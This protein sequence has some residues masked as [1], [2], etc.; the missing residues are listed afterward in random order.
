M[1]DKIEPALTAEQ[2]SD[3]ARDAL[4]LGDPQDK[5][6]PRIV[7][8]EEGLSVQ[9]DWGEATGA[10]LPAVIAIA[11]AALPDTDPRKITR[12]KVAAMRQAADEF[13]SY[14]GRDYG[15]KDNWGRAPEYFAAFGTET[16]KFA[17]ALASYLPA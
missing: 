11:N 17:D 13:L 4:I 12:E 10:P 15:P 7:A 1:T 8:D 3:L 9:D 5:H 2:W 6:S 16:I 14:L